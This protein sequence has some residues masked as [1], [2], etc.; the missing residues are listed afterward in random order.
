LGLFGSE[1]FKAGYSE[2]TLICMEGSQP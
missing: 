1:I 2:T